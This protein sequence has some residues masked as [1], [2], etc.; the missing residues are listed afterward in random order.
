M[1]DRCAPGLMRVGTGIDTIFLL[2]TATPLPDPNVLEG[3]AVRPPDTRAGLDPLSLL[4]SGGLLDVGN[5]V[6]TPT[7][8]SI[9]RITIRTRPDGER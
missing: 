2:T 1:V 4:L 3:E 7:G 9:E 8:W 6:T 5:P